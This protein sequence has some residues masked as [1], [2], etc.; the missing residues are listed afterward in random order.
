MVINNFNGLE[1]PYLRFILMIYNFSCG[2]RIVEVIFVG[3]RA[4][5]LPFLFALHFERTKHLSNL[6]NV[7]AS[8]L[9]SSH[10]GLNFLAPNEAKSKG[11]DY[12][13]TSVAI[14]AFHFSRLFR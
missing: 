12:V 3:C 1:D 4:Q 6:H 11:K 13:T 14:S 7:F 10:L 9:A 5:T 8:G 2:F